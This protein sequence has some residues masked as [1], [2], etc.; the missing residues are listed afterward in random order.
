MDAKIIANNGERLCGGTTKSE[1][2]GYRDSLLA[3]LL[4]GDVEA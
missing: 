4:R 1:I 2:M 3:D